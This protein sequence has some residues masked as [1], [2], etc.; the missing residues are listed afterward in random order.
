VAGGISKAR[1]M[2]NGFGGYDISAAMLD[3]VMVWRW[4]KGDIKS[5]IDSTRR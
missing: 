3:V 5:N 1:A 4:R 2:Q